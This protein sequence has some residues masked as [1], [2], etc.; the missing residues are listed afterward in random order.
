MVLS[1]G[2]FMNGQYQFAI[3]SGTSMATPHV[4]AAIALLWSHHP[5]CTATQIRYALAYTAKDMGSSGCDDYYGYG[6]IQVKNALDFLDSNNCQMAN[7]GQT[8][9][10]GQCSAVDVLPTSSFVFSP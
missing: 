8:V 2:L 3:Y 6:I 7:W 4:S 1:T 9:G 5:E 10:S